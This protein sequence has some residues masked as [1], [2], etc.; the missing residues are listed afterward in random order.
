M[1]GVAANV[2]C[3]SQTNGHISMTYATAMK[4]SVGE[5]DQDAMRIG[6]TYAKILVIVSV[7]L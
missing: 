2:A 6:R 5:E 3:D 7:A 1:K 4:T